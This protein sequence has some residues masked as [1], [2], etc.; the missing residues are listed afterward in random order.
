MLVGEK[1]IQEL[2]DDGAKFG[3]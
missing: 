1:Y 3:M 2:S